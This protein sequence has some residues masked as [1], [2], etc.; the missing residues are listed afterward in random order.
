VY[1]KPFVLAALANFLFFTNL[2][3]YFLL[4][5]Y[6]QTLGGR[7]G[8]IGSIMAM[9][10][11]AAVACQAGIGALLD[12]WGRKPFILLAAGVVTVVS[13]AFAASTTLGWHFYLL[14]FLQGGAFA[15]F[16]TS[17]L[18]LIA[19]LAPPSRRAEAVGIFGVSG[20]VTI[21]LAPAIGEMVL[22]AWGFRALFVGSVL[23]AVATLAVCLAT[24]IPGPETPEAFQG[25][26]SGFWETFSP[27]LM[28]AF[29]FG[30]AS[31]IVFVL[32]PPFA[33]QVGLPRIGPFYLVYTAM[34]IAV[35]FL[36]GRLADRFGRWLVIFPSLVGLA[37]GVLLFS[38]LRSTWLLLVIALINGISH[39]FVFPATS[40]LAFDRAPSGARGRALAA[41]NMAALAGGASG[42]IGFGWLAQL[43]G[44]RPGFVM[45]GLVLMVGA[46]LF[47]RKR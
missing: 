5:L 34:A 12:R 45:A 9:F 23:V 37:A 4:P 17:N 22:H 41:Y 18:T 36:G 8:Q 21:A 3:V 29:Q 10:S 42:A 47:W 6:I 32:L 30:L 44:Y 46:L 31:S 40:A 7:E 16:L 19:D 15:I 27:V 20:L 24:V 26:G 43:V 33:R 35:R 25:F 39:G 11:L 14:R 1:T 28:A 2:N 38:L 13:A